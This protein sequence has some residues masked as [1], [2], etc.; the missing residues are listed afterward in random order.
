MI[1][2][3]SYNR[4]NSHHN[5]A[6]DNHIIM[7]KEAVVLVNEPGLFLGIVVM[8]KLERMHSLDFPFHMYLLKDEIFKSSESSI[9]FGGLFMWY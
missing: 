6:D 2:L 3:Y 4:Y 8:E 1:V 7:L 5:C 9:F